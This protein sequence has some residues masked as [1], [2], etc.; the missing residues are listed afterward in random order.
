MQIPRGTRVLAESPLLLVHWEGSVRNIWDAF[1]TL[2]L[3]Q[4]A[5]YLGLH[6]YVS[7][8][9]KREFEAELGVEWKEFPP[10]VRDILQVFDANNLCLGVFLIGS[11]M[12]HSC[13]PN[14]F[15]TF[16]PSL[17]KLT[18]QVVRDIAAGE[19]L[20]TAYVN[21]IMRTKAERQAEL[22]KWGVD[23]TCETCADPDRAIFRDVKCAWM[24]KLD[25]DLV[26][27][28]HHGK[29]KMARQL[30]VRLAAMQQAEGFF[31][32]NLSTPYVTAYIKPNSPD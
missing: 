19:E 23:C 7:G 22:E 14:V 9:R 3:S 17:G 16:N 10:L 15:A 31:G 12:N 27:A 13:T 20:T 4:K 5:S 28:L 1:K 6:K 25:Q 8:P 26:S 11:R 30:A 2:S 32:Q 21:T 29:W 18:Y 24:Y